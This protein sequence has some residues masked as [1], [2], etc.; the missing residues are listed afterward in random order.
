V[1]C[2]IA[3]TIQ[4]IYFVLFAWPA[5]SAETNSANGVVHDATGA[6]IPGAAVAFHQSS[7]GTLVASQTG[8]HNRVSSNFSINRPTVS[9][10]PAPIYFDLRRSS[11]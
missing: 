5:M 2:H 4:L 11:K 1:K 6:L 9:G 10:N 8:E 7:S 3:L